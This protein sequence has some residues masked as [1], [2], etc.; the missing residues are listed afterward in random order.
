MHKFDFSNT[1][2][3]QFVAA[4]MLNPVSEEWWQEYG[5]QVIDDVM[6]T[7]GAQGAD[8]WDATQARQHATEDSR[9]SHRSTCDHCGAVFNY[10]A[11]FT[12]SETGET[13]IVGNVC[14]TNHL[15]LTAHQY[16]DKR[17][18]KTI[19]MLKSRFEGEKA[20]ANNEKRIAELPEPLRTA[21]NHTHYIC[22]DIRSYFVRKGELSEAQE[23]LLLKIYSED[24]KRKAGEHSVVMPVVEGKGITI[25]GRIVSTKTVESQWGLNTKMLVLDGRGF[26][27]WTTVPSAL[28]DSGEE[29]K[30]SHVEFIGN[31]KA[32]GDDKYFGF[33]QR[34]RKAQRL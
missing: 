16:L 34:P 19:K 25:R 2:Q 22:T 21:I 11:A 5:A 9:F 7:N 6:Y 33:A 15:N 3:W 17:M 18:R 32:S 12:N 1:E 24:M 31:V 10:G 28:F 26:K 20:R 14:A 13:A 8:I 29:L 27:I 4:V 23:K 30:G